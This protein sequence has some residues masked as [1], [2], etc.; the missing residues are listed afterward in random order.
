MRLFGLQIS[1]LLAATL[2]VAWAIG[3]HFTDLRLRYWMIPA[4]AV[5]VAPLHELTHALAFPRGANPEQ[6]T[7]LLWPRGFVLCARYRGVVSRNRYVLVLLMPLLA[8]SL[9]PILACAVFDIGSAPPLCIVLFMLNALASGEDV[10]AAVL[11]LSQVPADGLIR[12]DGSVTLWK[13]AASA[14]RTR[15]LAG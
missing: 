3:T 7:L 1:V 13:P 15:T 2:I 6:R 4:A 10:L 8:V 11:V 5:L 14:A 9:A 12:T